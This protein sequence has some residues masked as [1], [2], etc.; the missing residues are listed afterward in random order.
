[1]VRIDVIAYTE[2]EVIEETDVS[3]GRCRELLQT[4][5]VTWINIVDADDRTEQELETLFGLHPVALED[6]RETTAAPK[7]EVY[8][9]VL[10]LVARTILWGE[11][12]DTDQ[13]SL[14]LSKRF[15]ITMH[16]KVFPQLE[17]VRKMIRKK[18][19]RVL[20]AAPGFLAYLVL[21]VV[22][23]S[24]IP[25]LDKI[26]EKIDK[27]EDDIVRDPS[28]A[29][30]DRVHTLRT[31]LLQIRNSL[32]PQRDSFSPLL[33]IELPFFR[34]E[35]RNYLRD[36]YDQMLTSLDVLDTQR[37]TVTT[38]MELQATL[39]GSSANAAMKALTAVATIMLPLTVIAGVFGMN[40]AFFGAENQEVGFYIAMATMAITAI[41]TIF[42]IRR[43]GWL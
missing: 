38:L 17:S 29:R 37:E 1:M 41:I 34:K 5:T 26:E 6:A 42:W 28:G 33:R 24:Y 15:L 43:K 2:Q 39:M 16:D 3:L 18:D 40:V 8:D 11:E 22:V 13:L 25:V 32:R 35:T 4:H 12:L 21:D 23:D 36:V 20:K 27:L 19:A 14:F 9:H 7:V 10:Y 31:D 30:I